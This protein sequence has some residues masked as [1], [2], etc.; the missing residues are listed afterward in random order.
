MKDLNCAIGVTDEAVTAA[1]FDHPS[2]A[3]GLS[4]LGSH[5]GRRF[6]RTGA[7]KDLNRAVDVTDKAVTTTPPN[8]LIELALWH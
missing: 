2:R 8:I 1:P 4:I 7:T 5:L 6:K 3:S